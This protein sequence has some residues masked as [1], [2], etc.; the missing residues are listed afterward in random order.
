[1]VIGRKST[2]LP[3]TKKPQE[4]SCSCGFTVVAATVFDEKSVA[5]FSQ[6]RC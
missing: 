3:H 2:G 6:L 5:T 4:F 1:V